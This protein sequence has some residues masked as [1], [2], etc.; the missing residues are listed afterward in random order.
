MARPAVAPRCSTP[1]FTLVELVFSLLVVGIVTGVS[2]SAYRE[3]S[4]ATAVEQA[5]GLLAEDVSRTR[6]LAIQRREAVSLVPD[7]ANRSYVIRG[8]SGTLFAARDLG[9]DSDLPLT[10]LDLSPVD[11]LTFNAR[12]ILAGAS[13]A[14]VE[15]GRL[16]RTRRVTVNALGRVHVESE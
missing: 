16:G 7:E 11:S 12:G 10:L 13:A 8:P 9:S 4:R 3:Y 6:A 1:G 14:T 5:A 15:V 2:V